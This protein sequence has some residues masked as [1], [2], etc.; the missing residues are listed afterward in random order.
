MCGLLGSAERPAERAALREAIRNGT[1]ELC[2]RIQRGDADAGSFREA[3]LRQVRRTV[4]DKLLVTNPGWL[5][6]GEAPPEG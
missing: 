2:Q 5:G 3:V 1:S 6:E 4:R